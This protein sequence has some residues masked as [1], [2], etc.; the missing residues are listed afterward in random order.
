MGYMYIETPYI[1]MYIETPYI[2]MYIETPYITMYIE[3]PYITIYIETPHICYFLSEYIV[4]DM[5][6]KQTRSHLFSQS[7]MV[8][9]IANQH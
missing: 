1:T 4:D 7:W 6:L 3:T 2:T 8:S 9:S 5:V